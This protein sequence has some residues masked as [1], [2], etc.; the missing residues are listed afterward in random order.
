MK[1]N[2]VILG[3]SE[4]SEYVY[5]TIKKEGQINVLAFTVSRS[6]LESN[7]VRRYFNELPVVPLEDLNTHLLGMEYEILIT[8]GYKRMNEIREKMY[9][10]CKHLGYKIATYISSRAICDSDDI[11]EGCIIMPTAYVPPCTKIGKCNII[12]M[13][14]YITHTGFVGDFN[15]FAATIVMGGNIKMG[16]K[17]FI[18]MNC[19][20]KNGITV[21]T[22]TFLGAGSYLSCDSGEGRAYIGSPAIN[23]RNL[24]SDI[25]I[26][27]V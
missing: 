12:N 1:K 3:I 27:F 2:I 11:G 18:G 24:K 10:Y 13:G 15:W 20:L 21:G 26:D 16:S 9:D 23:K 7:N 25:V 6:W 17:C 19:V 8:V 5:Y 4:Y 22:K 14:T